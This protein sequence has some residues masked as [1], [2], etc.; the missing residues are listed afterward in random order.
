MDAFRHRNNVFAKIGAEQEVLLQKQHI[1][2]DVEKT[3]CNLSM[4]QRIKG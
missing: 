1:G 3:K 4:A 2:I